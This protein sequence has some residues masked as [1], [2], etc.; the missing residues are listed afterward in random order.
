M[1]ER[2]E[3]NLYAF[4]LEK[5]LPVKQRQPERLVEFKIRMAELSL[6]QGA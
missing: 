1:P 5:T 4:N 2:L 3:E 6:Q